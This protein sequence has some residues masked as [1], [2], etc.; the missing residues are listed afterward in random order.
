LAAAAVPV[1]VGTAVGRWIDHAAGAPAHG[2]GGPGGVIWWRAVCALV[3]GLAVQ[4]GTNYA[5][6]YS[7]GVRGT[8]E[9][10]VGPVRL[11]SSGLASPEAVRNA[12]LASFGVAA[13]AGLALAAATSW[14]LIAVGVLRRRVAVHG[15]PDALRLPGAG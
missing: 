8:D 1:V 5:N 4:I 11:V 13:V 10:R 12:A 3:I 15:G 7:D 6:D 9:R 2:L 14:W